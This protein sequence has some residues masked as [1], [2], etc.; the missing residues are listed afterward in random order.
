MRRKKKK[1]IIHYVSSIQLLNRFNRRML[2]FSNAHSNQP[3]KLY[4]C[5][6]LRYDL[7]IMLLFMQE[8]YHHAIFSLLILESLKDLALLLL[9]SN[10]IRYSM[11][12]ILLYSCLVFQ[13]FL[14][15][16]QTFFNLFYFLFF[17]CLR[18]YFFFLGCVYFFF[19]CFF[20]FLSCFFSFLCFLFFFLILKINKLS[21][22]F[23]I[24]F[25]F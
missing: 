15:K 9:Q 22:F 5:G 18:W 16:M 25:I 7:I 3:L 6:S 10:L 12:H 1:P 13:S 24:V 20:F 19:L 2:I 11:I 4:H 23:S 14:I 17:F 8:L 21:F